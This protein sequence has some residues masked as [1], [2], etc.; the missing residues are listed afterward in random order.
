MCTPQNEFYD[1]SKLG[2]AKSERTNSTINNSSAFLYRN[3][4]VLYVVLQS[5]H[6]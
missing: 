3:R 1:I 2:V 5:I 6:R 4:N